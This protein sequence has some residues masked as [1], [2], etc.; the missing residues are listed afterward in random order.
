MFEVGDIVRIVT[1]EEYNSRGYNGG[2]GSML[3]SFSN[4]ICQITKKENDNYRLAVIILKNK[5]NRS[6]NIQDYWWAGKYLEY[7]PQTELNISE[8]E[9][10]SL[11]GA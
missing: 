11:L 4:T 3:D 10:N 2:E 7:Y 1:I 5:F 8:D 6:E 9:I